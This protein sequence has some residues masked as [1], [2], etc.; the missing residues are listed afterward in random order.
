MTAHPDHRVIQFL[1]EMDVDFTAI[2]HHSE[3]TITHSAHSAH[4]PGRMVM[5][6]ILLMCNDDPLMLVLAATHR[7]DFDLLKMSYS[8]STLQ[9]ASREDLKHYFPDCM[10]DAIPPFGDLYDI[11]MIVDQALCENDYV[12][13]HPGVDD[14]LIRMHFNTYEH[15]LNPKF[16]V[17]S[18]P[19][20]FTNA[21]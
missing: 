12:Y 17:A 14:T 4:V 5:K 15:L 16:V 13:F 11:A 18:V 9:L 7:I 1:R 6:P 10:I 19:N 21:H 3:H 2:E 20:R 8:C